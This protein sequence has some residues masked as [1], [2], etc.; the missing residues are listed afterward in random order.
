M[1][2]GVDNLSTAYAQTSRLTPK[3][4]MGGFVRPD[5]PVLNNFIS[6]AP[7]SSK[8]TRITIESRSD[9][10]NRGLGSPVNGTVHFRPLIAHPKRDEPIK[11][12]EKDKSV[13]T[14]KRVYLNEYSGN[15]SE[16]TRKL[17]MPSA[18]IQLFLSCHDYVPYKPFNPVKEEYSSTKGHSALSINNIRRNENDSSL[19][20]NRV[21]NFPNEVKLGLSKYPSLNQPKLAENRSPEYGEMPE[22]EGPSIKDS[23][24]LA[25]NGIRRVNSQSYFLNPS[26]SNQNNRAFG[27]LGTSRQSVN[28]LL[29]E[30]VMVHANL[31]APNNTIRNDKPMMP[32][33]KLENGANLSTTA[34]LDFSNLKDSCIIAENTLGNKQRCDQTQRFMPNSN[35]GPKL[36]LRDEGNKS[37]VDRFLSDSRFITSNQTFTGLNTS[38]CKQITNKEL[39]DYVKSYP[40]EEN[41]ERR[42]FYNP[43]IQPKKSALKKNKSMILKKVT[44]A[45]HNNRRFEVSKWLQEANEIEDKSVASPLNDEYGLNETYPKQEHQDPKPSMQKEQPKPAFAPYQHNFT[46]YGYETKEPVHQGLRSV[47]SVGVIRRRISICDR[48]VPQLYAS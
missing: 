2:N 23:I 10:L 1:R 39:D 29:K 32:V 19:T 7:S 6:Q 14:Q 4:T 46:A 8:L 15:L 5:G 31:K 35:G 25:S 27:T 17:G 16:S 12:P 11:E 20:N 36:Q 40:K 18:D 37:M 43:K 44:I 41:T 47:S 24:I 3:N 48:N 33:K 45:E 22:N 21:H 30:N 26:V 9:T 34:K 42:S 13:F 38:L 28:Q